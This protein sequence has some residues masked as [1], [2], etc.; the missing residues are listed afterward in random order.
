MRRAMKVY[1]SGYMY[2]HL[3]SEKRLRDA[4]KMLNGMGYETV[5]PYDV[6]PEGSTREEAMRHRLIYLLSCDALYLAPGYSADGRAVW[7][8]ITAK[9]CGLTVMDGKVEE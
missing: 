7:E 6:V 5:T 1:V 3:T 9:L 4:E 8:Q 2:G